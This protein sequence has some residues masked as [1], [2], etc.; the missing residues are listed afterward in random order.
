VKLLLLP[1]LAATLLLSSCQS[2]EK[3]KENTEAASAENAENGAAEVVPQV[4]KSSAGEN[5]KTQ[6]FAVAYLDFQSALA[7]GDEAQSIATA[8]K[9]ASVAPEELKEALMQASKN[10]ASQ[11]AIDSLRTLLPALT[12][13]METIVKGGSAKEGTYYKQFCPMA[14]NDK[15]AFWFSAAPEIRNPYF[16][17]AMLECGETKEA[18]EV[19]K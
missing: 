8:A 16:A 7:K 19:K 2:S 5:D 11:G 9:L 14:F 13:S 3:N 15:G 10:Q 18:F 17:D 6:A 1:F 12:K 4:V